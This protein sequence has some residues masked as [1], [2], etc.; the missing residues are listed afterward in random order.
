[1]NNA[2]YASSHERSLGSVAA[3]IRDEL[4]DFIHTRVQ[5]FKTELQETLATFKHVMPM[6]VIALTLLATAYVL[7]TLAVVS[8]VAVAF[9]SNPYH[10]FFA[11]LIVGGVWLIAGAL[12][13]F[14]VWNRIKGH[15]TFPRRTIGVLKAD[16]I[17]LQHEARS[18]P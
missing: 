9:W 18:Q 17:W 11:F 13:A 7:L 12:T 15:G 6:A 3:E 4:L 2:A 5:M 10:W 14:L 8:V 16:K 1:M